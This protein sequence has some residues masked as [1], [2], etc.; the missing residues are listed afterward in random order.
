MKKSNKL[1][2]FYVLT[3]L[4]LFFTLIGGGVYG[5][6]ISVGLNFAKSSVP[7]IAGSGE[8]NNVALQST[9]NYTPS[10]TGIIILSIILIIL[11]IFDFVIMIKQV[12]F[13]KQFKIV[14]DSKLERKI[15]T[16]TKSKNSV[17]FWTFF[18]DIISFITGIVGLFIN[19][20]SF[21]G[22]SNYS[23]VFYAVD[24]L[25]SIFSLFSI[26]LLISKLKN[27]N[28]TSRKDAKMPSTRAN[29]IDNLEQRESLSMDAKDINQMEYNLI[30]LEAMKRSKLVS[31]DEYKKIRRKILT[32]Q[33]N[34]N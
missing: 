34:R 2:I 9:V 5:I 24:I 6:Y 28:N 30:K 29:K 7:N 32:G 1:S 27:R 31:E 15:E 8:I 33:K 18:F 17:I 10:M 22:R 25:V 19:N 3:V 26:I 20:R 11:A 23:W 14:K 21:A 12:V 13:F 16:K 4:A